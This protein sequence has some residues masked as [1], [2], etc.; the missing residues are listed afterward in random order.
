MKKIVVVIG[1]VVVV[2]VAAFWFLSVQKEEGAVEPPSAP[3]TAEEP[4]QV[5]APAELPDEKPAE[6]PASAAVSSPPSPVAPPA[7][8]VT[9]PVAPEKPVSPADE[10]AVR[11]EPPKVDGLPPDV[12]DVILHLW[13][14]KKTPLKAR[15]ARLASIADKDDEK[16]IETLM[17]IGKANIYLSGEAVELLAGI[18]S[19]AHNARIDEYLTERLADPDVRIARS[20]V[21]AYGTRKGGEGAQEMVAAL[22]K[23]R[24]RPDGYGVEVRTEIVKALKEIAEPTAVPGL[25]KEFDQAGKEDW[26]LE[27]GSEIVSALRVTG[28]GDAKAAITGYADML[29][30]RIPEDPLAKKY[31]EDKIAEARKAASEMR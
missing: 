25:K 9:P 29:A 17:A 21:K 20:A 30:K 19:D 18:Y 6:I 4:V 13:D 22:E 12:G 3:P 5:P 23:N 7:V 28:T 11:P 2:G 27:Y 24:T 15:R 10:A 16:S 14:A 1:L 8:A 26:S 31:F